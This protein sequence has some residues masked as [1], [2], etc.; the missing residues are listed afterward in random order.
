MYEYI[1]IIIVS[2]WITISLIYGGLLWIKRK[3]VPDRSRTYL[4]VL[5]FLTAIG[6]SNYIVAA[7]RDWRAL[8]YLHVRLLPD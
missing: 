6:I 8:G 3:E 4:S 7:I 5:C 1:T 2:I